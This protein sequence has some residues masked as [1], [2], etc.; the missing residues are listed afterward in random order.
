MV[1]LPI[2]QNCPKA[3]YLAQKVDIQT[4]IG[5]VLDGGS[6]ILGEETSAFEEEF[7]KHVG[8]RFGIGVGS[9]TDALVLALRALDIGEGKAVVTVSIP[10][11]QQ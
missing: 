1:Q 6:Y 7:A 11:S 9:G 8:C 5:R 3:A 4:A 10:R 2:P